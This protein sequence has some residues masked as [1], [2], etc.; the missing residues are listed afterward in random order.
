[1]CPRGQ[2][3]PLDLTVPAGAKQT[4]WVLFE[5]LVYPPGDEVEQE[6]YRQMLVIPVRG[7]PSLTIMINNPVR[8][9]RGSRRAPRRYGRGR[10]VTL[11]PPAHFGSTTSI[12]ARSVSGTRVVEW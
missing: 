3:G 5:P 10:A 11:V 4:L 7:G 2:H 1:M 8:V 9:L 12:S 6:F